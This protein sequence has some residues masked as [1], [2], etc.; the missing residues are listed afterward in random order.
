MEYPFSERAQQLKPSA[1]REILKFSS[2]PNVISFSAGNPS[3]E[4]F[5]IEAIRRI[6][7]DILTNDPVAALQYSI[8]EGLPALREAVR[9]DLSSRLLIG[10][11]HDDVIIATGA[12][13][14]L[15]LTARAFCRPGDVVVCENPSFLGALNAFRAND[16]ELVGVDINEDGVDLNQ[17]E[18]AFASHPSARF[19]YTIPNFQN[20]T[21]ITM[22]RQKRKD[23]YFLAKKYGVLIL[24]DNPYGDLR[25]AG[26]ALPAIKTLDTDGIVIYCGSFSKILAPGLRVAFTSAPKE[27][28]AKMVVLKQTSDVHTNVLSQMI[29]HRFLTEYPLKEHLARLRG[30]YRRKAALMLQSIQ[31][32]FPREVTCTKPEGGLF[33]WCTLPRDCDMLSFCKQAVLEYQVAVVP[34]NA[35]MVDS[36]LPCR[37]FRLNYSAPPD[38]QIVRGIRSLGSL[39]RHLFYKT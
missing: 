21:G 31:D 20:P 37:S 1:I 6:A 25:F 4:A 27:I 26:E 12:Q 19:F 9:S 11:A 36:S 8:T 15:D 10:S 7:N 22:S 30:I 18:S 38:D 33:L 3:Q 28:A 16:A 5:P 29:A 14:V 35:F 24:E 32:E 17:L 34:G 39:L 13:Q 23:V 2:D